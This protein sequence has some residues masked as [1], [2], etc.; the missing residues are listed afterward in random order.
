MIKSLILRVFYSFIEDLIRNISG[1]I[2][3][4]LRRYYY[5][6]RAYRCGKRLTIGIGVYI[7]NPQCMKFG[8]DVWID[9]Y[10]S[11][12]AGDPGD[13]SHRDVKTFR[14]RKFKQH[15]GTLSFGSQIHLAPYSIIS[16]LA[17]V[18]IGDYCTFSTGV[19]IYSMSN[20]YRSHSSPKLRSFS[21]PMVRKEPVSII[22][23]PIKIGENVFLSTNVTVFGGNIGDD[24]FVTSNSVI[25]RDIGSNLIW[26]DD[27][28]MVTRFEN[29]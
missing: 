12:Y 26:K 24:T 17:G 22:K 20:H 18:E 19:K 4:R 9:N 7:E 11:L 23:Y 16:A 15:S 29:H 10:C 27:N 8:D 5:G 6:N 21:N 13:L 25:F 2:G 14:N 3:L 28:T 1:P